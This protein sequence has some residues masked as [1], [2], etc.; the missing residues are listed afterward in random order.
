MIVITMGLSDATIVLKWVERIAWNI[1]I[2]VDICLVGG[3][4]VIA[5]IVILA[6][7]GNG[8]GMRLVNATIGVHHGS[9]CSIG[10][11]GKERRKEKNE[12][13]RTH[14]HGLLPY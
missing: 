9:C 10:T 7:N 6:T 12:I 2:I 4:I 5:S 1:V 8:V 11:K 3:V 13:R 14:Q